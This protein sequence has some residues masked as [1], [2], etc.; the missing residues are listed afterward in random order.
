MN[1]SI[2]FLYNL[3]ETK[4][5]SKMNYNEKKEIDLIISISKK[6]NIALESDGKL[7]ISY[8]E[9]YYVFCIIFQFGTKSS[10][11]KLFTSWV[12]LKE[13]LEVQIYET[14]IL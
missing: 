8:L 3:K 9:Q 7:N 4:C 12:F 10:C 11:V 14:I 13:Q 6:L 2:A 1:V 5:N